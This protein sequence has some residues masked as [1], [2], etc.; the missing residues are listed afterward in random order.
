MAKP[1]KKITEAKKI[2]KVDLVAFPAHESIRF[3][4]FLLAS[5]LFPFLIYALTLAPTVTFEDSGELITAAR[6]LGVPHEPGYPLFVIFGRFFSLFPFDNIAFRINL[7]SAFFNALAALFLFRSFLMALEEIFIRTK[8]WKENDEGKMVFL[9]YCLALSG[10]LFWS[11]AFKTWEQSVITEVYGVNDF[12]L[13]LFLFFFLKWRRQ[14]VENKRGRLFNYLCLVTG[15]AVTCHSSS[16][17]LVP[18]LAGYILLHERKI[19]F[20][21]KKLVKP[22]LFFSCGLLPW[23]YLPFASLA[24]PPVDWGNPENLLNMFRVITRHQYQVQEMPAMNNPGEVFGFYFLEMLP[25]QWYFFLLVLLPVGII[26]LYKNAKPL[27]HL[28][29][30]YL[31]MSVFVMSYMTRDFLGN[32]ENKALASVFYIPSYMFVSLLLCTGL[33]YLISLLRVSGKLVYL[34]SIVSVLVACSSVIRNYERVNMSRY[35]FAEQYAGNIFTLPDKALLFINWD[36]FGFP[37]NYYQ[38]VEK[39]RND[40]IVLDELLLKR[41]WYI[42]WLRNYY[43][44]FMYLSKPEVDAF[45]VAVA[46]F[47]AGDEYNGN[48]IQQ[49]YIG[50]INSFIDNRM[51]AGNHVYFTYYPEKNIMRNNFLEPQFSA[52]KYTSS[53]V[54]DT[55]INDKNIKLDI[56]LNE[57]ITHDRMADYMSDYYGNLYGARAEYIER[58]GN[59]GQ[60]LALYRKAMKLFGPKNKKTE[61]I[62]RR[63]SLLSR[64]P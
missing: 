51:K 52:Y 17:M 43:P 31:F 35:Y 13:A 56:F 32:S 6:F 63:I 21:Y 60:C 10:S 50:M 26:I 18:V 34:F 24:N 4:L 61:Y 25:D 20:E 64:I 11:L 14:V 7:M 12:F 8:F 36:P 19:I 53:P 28:T 22:I 5:F 48:L 49:K 47:E 2:Q 59:K 15:L 37:L 3:K 55:L 46:P 27:F 40:I 44:E 42:E 16:A 9:S 57:N 29:L 62:N 54:P 58:Y 41:S 33:F 1:K 23:L 30:L 39:K 45:L 38:F